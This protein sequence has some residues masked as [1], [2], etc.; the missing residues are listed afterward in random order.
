MYP[1]MLQGDNLVIVIDNTPHTINKKHFNYQKVVEAIKQG[2]KET[3]KNVISPAKV[4]LNITHGQIEIKDDKLHYQG[5]E[6]HNVLVERIVNMIKEGFDG[7]PFL[8]FL[9]NLMTNPS[10]R[11]VDELYTFLE[12]GNLPITSDGCFLAYKKVRPDYLDIHSGTISNAVGQLVKMPRNMVDD[13]ASRTCS[14]GLHFCSEE[15]LK[16]FGS[17]SDPVMILK[18]NPR[19]VVSIPADYNA[20]KGRCCEYL[21]VGQVGVAEAEITT[22]AV[23]DLELE[24]ELNFDDQ[25]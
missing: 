22:N 14:T 20:T 10:K 1:Y 12:K 19:D 11:A 13:V 25:A 15:Y 9:D 17:R 21:V 2:D 18:I 5:Y 6:I 8:A 7:T 4:I 16:N 24:P 3:V 23:Q